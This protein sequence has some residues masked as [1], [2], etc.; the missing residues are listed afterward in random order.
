DATEFSVPAVDLKL[1]FDNIIKHYYFPGWHQQSTFFELMI[2]LDKWN[3]LSEQQQAQINTTCG[4]NIR[5]AIAEGEA[6]QA[7]AIVELKSRGTIFHQW[8]DEFLDEF[9]KSWYEVAAEEAEK[10]EDF[11]RSWQSL[12]QFRQSYKTWKELGYL[13]ADN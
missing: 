5:F 11:K 6:L 13:K 1:G 9:E 3:S 7:E 4:D 8:P 2:N 10:D 12:Q